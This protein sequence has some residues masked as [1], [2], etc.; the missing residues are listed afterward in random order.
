M[1]DPVDLTSLYPEN[2]WQ[3]IKLHLPENLNSFVNQQDLELDNLETER[4]KQGLSSQE[5]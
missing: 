3:A 5:D 1:G 2:P 4:K